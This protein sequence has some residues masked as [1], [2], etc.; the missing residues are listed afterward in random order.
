MWEDVIMM[1]MN[2]NDGEGLGSASAFSWR[3]AML[4]DFTHGW[5]TVLTLPARASIRAW[6]IKMP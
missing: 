1:S 6:T 3:L 5:E 2:G 4:F